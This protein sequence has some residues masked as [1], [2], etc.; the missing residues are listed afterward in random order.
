MREPLQSSCSSYRC[1]SDHCDYPGTLGRVCLILISLFF[2]SFFLG[3]GQC[4]GFWN[5]LLLGAL[6]LWHLD[7]CLRKKWH[8]YETTLQTCG[9]A[10][11]WSPSFFSVIFLPEVLYAVTTQCKI[12]IHI[13]AYIAEQSWRGSENVSGCYLGIHPDVIFLYFNFLILLF[14]CFVFFLNMPVTTSQDCQLQ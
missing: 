2:F 5:S 8:Y 3:N 11:Q 14:F 10:L 13:K 7:S 4:S 6:L 9:P 1:V 12:S